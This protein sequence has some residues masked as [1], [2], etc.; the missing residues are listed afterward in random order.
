MPRSSG[1]FAV[2]SCRH[3]LTGTLPGTPAAPESSGFK[4]GLH[5]YIGHKPSKTSGFEKP[6][7]EPAEYGHVIPF[8]NGSVACIISQYRPGASNSLTPDCLIIDE[9]K[10][11]GFE[12]PKDETFPASGGCRG[13][14]GTRP[15]HRGMLIMSGMPT[16]QK[17]S[18]FMRYEREC[19]PELRTAIHGIVYEIRRLKA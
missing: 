7:I 2:P 15:Y 4:C 6:Y 3:G 14:S 11:A 10:F 5:H 1:A 19:D 9:A 17:G 18:R 12:Q 13:H 16:A 8:H